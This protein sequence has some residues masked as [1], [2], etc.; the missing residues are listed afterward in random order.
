M[1]ATSRNRAG[2]V[3]VAAARATLTTP[4]SR[5]WR[6]ASMTWGA[7]SAS[8]SRKRTP[9]V[10]A[11][12]SPGRIVAVPPPT[13][14]TEEAPWWGA[15]TGGWGTSPPAGSAHAGGGWIL[16]VSSGIRRR[17][18]WGRGSQYG[19]TSVVGGT[20]KKKTGDKE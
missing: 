20:F 3:T 14:A 1:A 17:A 11:L 6:S 18:C 12:I 8:S 19:T 7:N 2:K 9:L 15:L 13:R 4:S 10:A 5:G 16:G